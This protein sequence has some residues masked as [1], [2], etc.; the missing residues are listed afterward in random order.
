MYFK[1]DLFEFEDEKKK[2][3]EPKEKH[4]RKV[5]QNLN[6]GKVFYFQYKNNS[7]EVLDLKTK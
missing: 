4:L 5:L 3:G 1:T 7:V 2:F 6:I